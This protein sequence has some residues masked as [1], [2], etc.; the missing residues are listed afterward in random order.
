VL[1]SAFLAK[2][3]GMIAAIVGRRSLVEDLL[4]QLKKVDLL[5]DVPGAD[6]AVK[7][8]QAGAN[9]VGEGFRSGVKNVGEGVATGV[10]TVR[11]F[12]AQSDKV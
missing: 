1:V 8:V 9:A 6:S 7:G 3:A 11:N 12:G 5:T 2:F 4:Q 10:E